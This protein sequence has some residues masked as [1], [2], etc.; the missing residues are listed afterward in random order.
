MAPKVPWIFSQFGILHP[1]C[2]LKSLSFVWRTAEEIK[3]KANVGFSCLPLR[4]LVPISLLFGLGCRQKREVF[5]TAI[6]SLMLPLKIVSKLIAYIS[7][8]IFAMY[9][10]FFWSLKVI[11]RFW[12]RE[13][14]V[15]V[16]INSLELHRKWIDD[17][18]R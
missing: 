15:N 2:A 1:E 8:H 16:F 14:S 5:I 6:R 12:G 7:C 3:I 13:F 9:M 18:G 11:F 17:R 4:V 10:N